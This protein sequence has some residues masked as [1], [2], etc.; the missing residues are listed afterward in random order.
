M[1]GIFGLIRTSTSPEAAFRST[2]AFLSL[3]NLSE[4]RGT[5]SSGIAAFTPG[6][7]RIKATEITDAEAAQE[8]LTV[9]GVQII[10]QTTRFSSM[11]LDAH[12]VT[13]NAS[14]VLMGHTRWAT[15]GSADDLRNASPMVAGSLVGTHNGDVEIKS[16]PNHKN[17][18]GAAFGG[19]DTER[20][21][22]AV[23]EAR[24][25][26]REMTKVLKAVKGRAALVFFDRTRQDRIYIART[27]L[28][29]VAYAYTADGDFMYASN[30]D[31][32]RQV[33]RATKGVVSFKDITLVPEGHLLT[34]DTTLGQVTDIRRFTPTCRERDIAMINSAAYKK[35][36]P[37][38][39]AAFTALHRHKIAAAKLPKWPTLTAAPK[40]QPKAS[41]AERMTDDVQPT[42][43]DNDWDDPQY[44]YDL[45]DGFEFENLPPLEVLEELCWAS[46][47]FDHIAYETILEE[48]DPD[49]VERLVKELKADVLS[50]IAQGATYPGFEMPTWFDEQR[51]A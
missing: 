51:P 41:K 27:A 16:I 23:D 46:G 30:P 32:F 24:K 13:I 42:L 26:R 3:G 8:L 29:P 40:V 6:P 15:Q 48:T 4:E 7:R 36:T 33:E 19:T 9:D 14:R 43:F 37:E 17:H 45:P 31:W 2:A 49:E 12:M 25:D 5:D 50:M 10:R 20:I 34:I 28:S 35:F 39:R 44:A 1:C 47:D 22:L 21:Y 18:D 38:D 11:A